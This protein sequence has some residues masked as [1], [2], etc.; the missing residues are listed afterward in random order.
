M[1]ATKKPTR[2]LTDPQ[3]RLVNYLRTVGAATEPGIYEA[4]VSDATAQTLRSLLQRGIVRPLSPVQTAAGKLVLYTL[5][6]GSQVTR[7]AGR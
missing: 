4:G 2:R 6:E 7:A 5:P 3:A 1:P